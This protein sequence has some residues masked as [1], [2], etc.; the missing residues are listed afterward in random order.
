MNF[1]NDNDD[2]ND[3][4]NNSEYVDE[5]NSYHGTNNI[6]KNSIII[7]IYINHNNKN[8]LRQLLSLFNNIN[9]LR[10]NYSLFPSSI[11]SKSLIF[12]LSIVKRRI[13]FT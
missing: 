5:N 8:T 1:N 6:Q 11:I 3:V 4:L 9:N 12:S 10:N 2:S 13:V 7:D